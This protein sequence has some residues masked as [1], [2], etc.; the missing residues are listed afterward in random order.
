MRAIIAE[1]YAYALPL[2]M[3][4]L[5]SGL[6]AYDDLAPS[7]IGVVW[8]LLTGLCYFGIHTP[9]KRISHKG[10]CFVFGAAL[11]VVGIAASGTTDIY[12]D[13]HPKDLKE[14][15]HRAFNVQLLSQLYILFAAAVGGNAVFQGLYREQSNVA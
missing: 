8:A 9:L 11:I 4:I 14:E 2:L 13:H 12:M 10:R 3:V 6:L 15:T 5:F 1:F 7:V